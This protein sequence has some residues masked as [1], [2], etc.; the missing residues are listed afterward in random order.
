MSTRRP[1]SDIEAT[2][3]RETI[4]RAAVQPVSED[5]LSTIPY[6]HVVGR[7]GCGCATVHFEA[8]SRESYPIA[9]G[10]GTTP[11]GGTVGVIVW[12][13]SNAITGLEVL[14]SE[15]D[16]MILSCR[17]QAR[18][19]RGSSNPDARRVTRCSARC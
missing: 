14:I 6:I 17:W 2:I 18:F 3:V 9:E 16:H 11:S 19:R 10:I 5:L 15:P 7:C 8:Q 12:G 1:I 4:Q 13:T